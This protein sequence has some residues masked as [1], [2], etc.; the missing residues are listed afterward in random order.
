MESFEEILRNYTRQCADEDEE[1]QYLIKKCMEEVPGLTE[2][3][4]RE[5]IC[6]FFES[7]VEF[8]LDNDEDEIEIITDSTNE[9]IFEL[10][11][12]EDE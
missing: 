12:D 7:A 1:T 11:D 6:S 5:A 2:E 4:A 9:F 10:L 8:T 3:Q